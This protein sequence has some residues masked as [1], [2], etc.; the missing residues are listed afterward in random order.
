[1]GNTLLWIVGGLF[2]VLLGGFIV[3]WMLSG[4]PVSFIDQAARQ[5]WR[6]DL[7]D[8]SITVYPTLVRTGLEERFDPQSARKI[9]SFLA[10]SGFGMA[11]TSETAPDIETM[12]H[13]NELRVAAASAESLAQFVEGEELAT[14]YAL[15][16]EYTFSPKDGRV[17]A[18]HYYIVTKLG[19]VSDAGIIN[20]HHRIFQEIDPHTLEDCTE[21]AMVHM[22]HSWVSSAEA[23][24]G[25]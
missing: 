6:S 17:M 7:G 3:I 8:T 24:E 14:A 23:T 5:Q 13:R 10:E 1:M 9:S 19:R 25:D 22:E 16:A 2:A 12:W 18:V 4:G 20:S 21:L 11:V 15:M